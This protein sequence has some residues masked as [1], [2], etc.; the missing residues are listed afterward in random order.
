MG[1]ILVKMMLGAGL[2]AMVLMVAAVRPTMA[3]DSLAVG[4]VAPDFSLPFATKDTIDRTG[5]TL[6]AEAKKGPILLAFYPAD[7]SGGCTKEMCSFRDGF[8]DFEK[9]GVRVWAISGDYVYS[10]HAWAKAENFPFELLSDHLHAVAKLYGVYNAES[11]M[12]KRSVFVV[13]TDGKLLYVDREYSVA[14]D[15]DLN[16]LKSELAEI[17]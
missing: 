1:E 8:S 3:A 6:S 4:M 15:T 2:I 5:L 13:G 16:R 12:N 17:E 7:F 14:D 9:L 10:H 11:G